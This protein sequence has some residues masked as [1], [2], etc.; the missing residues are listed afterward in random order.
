MSEIVTRAD[1]LA[2]IQKI[3]DD[4]DTLTEEY[5][6][7]RE[8]AVAPM[9]EPELIIGLDG[10]KYRV[11]PVHSNTTSYRM[12]R[13]DELTPE[14]RA[15]VTEVKITSAKLQDAVAKD[16]IT[17]DQVARLVRFTP[18]KPYPKFD[19]IPD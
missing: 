11:S 6:V 1:K 8:E 5:E 4:I 12:D 14:Q 10:K 2:R 17:V 3:R 19:P 13:L 16:L 7:L 18:K 15:A 9:E